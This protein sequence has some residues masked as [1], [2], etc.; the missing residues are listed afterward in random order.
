LKNAV[1]HTKRTRVG[2][3]EGRKG[4]RFVLYSLVGKAL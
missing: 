4:T 1:L 3:G 2:E